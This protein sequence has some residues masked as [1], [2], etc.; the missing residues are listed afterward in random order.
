[1]PNCDNNDI[2]KGDIMNMKLANVTLIRDELVTSTI[3]ANQYVETVPFW[4]IT[5]APKH[6]IF[7]INETD[8]NDIVVYRADRIYEITTKNFE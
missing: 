6:V 1:M 3:I 8:E 7:H 2:C 5:W 4:K